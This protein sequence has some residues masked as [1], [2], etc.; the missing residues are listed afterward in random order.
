MF[1][2]YEKGISE[3]IKRVAKKS[4]VEIIFTKGQTLKNKLA[5]N[6]RS[7]LMDTEGVVYMAGCKKEAK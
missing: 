3:K 5:N 1:M 2:P 4:R 6:T 7:N